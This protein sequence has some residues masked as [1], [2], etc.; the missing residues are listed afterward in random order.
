MLENHVRATML[1]LTVN[2]M[3]SEATMLTNK[4]ETVLDPSEQEKFMY[5]IPVVELVLARLAQ[6]LPEYRISY[7]VGSM[8]ALLSH[9]PVTA[10]YIVSEMV[11]QAAKTGTTMVTMRC[12]DVFEE[13]VD[14]TTPE[15]EEFMYATYKPQGKWLFDYPHFW[16]NLVAN[17]PIKE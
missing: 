4:Y 1:R 10:L 15:Y 5:S 6:Y 2:E 14:D 9:N 3:W 7:G 8:V 16:A 13:W 12:V 17:H 11:R